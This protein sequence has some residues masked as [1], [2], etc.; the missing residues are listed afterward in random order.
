MDDFRIEPFVPGDAEDIAVC[1]RDIYGDSFPLRY[2]YDPGQIIARFDG[3]NHLALVARTRDGE[4]A[5]VGAIFRIGHNPRLYEIG[6]FMVKK[7]FRKHGLS[8]AFMHLILEDY[9][10]RVSAQAI[11]G[12][13][14]CNH[15][16]S[17][18]LAVNFGFVPTGL[19]LHW[20]PAMSFDNSREQ[21]D[22]SL[23][24][25]FHVI[26]DSPQAI[27]VPRKYAGYI[28][29]C[30]KA[31]G[32]ERTFA[33]SDAHGHGESAYS[34][35]IATD[36]KTAELTVHS[37]GGDWPAVLS[38]FEAATKGR[39]AH[40]TVDLGHPAAPWVVSLLLERGYFLAAFLPFWFGSDGIEL[41]KL[42][43]APDF[44]S[45]ELLADEAKDVAEIIRKDS[46][47]TQP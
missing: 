6:Q 43:C 39:I 33:E 12:Q 38:D 10:R 32:L 45:L 3:K 35:T 9:S 7:A 42:P 1:Y 2:V 17:Q 4:F 8:N 31:L 13:N 28:R 46:I 26:Q 36:A 25:C 5:G 22:I 21:R 41:Q 11:F 40:V 47:R 34:R 20:L 37:A 19:E 15:T 30:C 24:S 23:L 27:H 18:H 44:D 16:Y 14:V 29:E